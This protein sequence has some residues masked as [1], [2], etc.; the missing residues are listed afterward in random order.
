MV[1]GPFLGLQSPF[2]CPAVQ[3]VEDK[4]PR[5]GYDTSSLAWG[6]QDPLIHTYR[7]LPKNSQVNGSR[8]PDQIKGR[9]TWEGTLKEHGL[10]VES[11]HPPTFPCNTDGRG[12]KDLTYEE[13]EEALSQEWDNHSMRTG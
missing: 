12:F 3:S 13:Q 7:S 1:W 8:R 4:F 9:C 6:R 10:P 11:V 5:Y 2:V